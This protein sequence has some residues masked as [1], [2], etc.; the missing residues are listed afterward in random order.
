MTGNI[1]FYYFKNVFFILELWSFYVMIKA[2][3]MLMT[4]PT[5]ELLCIA[6]RFAIYF[7]LTFAFMIWLHIEYSTLWL[8]SHWTFFSILTF[9][10]PTMFKVFKNY[11]FC[12][13]LFDGSMRTIHSSL[14]MKA[15]PML[16]NGKKFLRQ[17]RGRK[18]NELEEGVKLS[19]FLLSIIFHLLSI[20]FFLSQFFSFFLSFILSVSLTLFLSHFHSHFLFHSIFLNWYLSRLNI[21]CFT[22]FSLSEKSRNLKITRWSLKMSFSDRLCIFWQRTFSILK[23]VNVIK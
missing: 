17:E 2:N 6:F 22:S 9:V 18:G 16:E 12:V 1:S 23:K 19:T 15:W 10:S 5:T 20:S 21:F 14:N 13:I 4:V 8:N 3:L 11:K 7:L